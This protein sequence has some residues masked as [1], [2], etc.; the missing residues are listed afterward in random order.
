MDP[1]SKDCTCICHDGP[2]W[3]HEDIVRR[4]LNLKILEGRTDHLALVAFAQE[5]KARIMDKLNWMKRYGIERIPAEWTRPDL[6]RK[7]REL[8]ARYLSKEG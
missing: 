3:L 5:E 1:W 8:L 6:D 4:T 2:H 7:E